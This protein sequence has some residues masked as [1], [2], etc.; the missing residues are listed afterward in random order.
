[1][2]AWFARVISRKNV[3]T[4]CLY[5]LGGLLYGV[6]LSDPRYALGAWLAVVSLAA[7]IQ[8]SRSPYAVLV[9]VLLAHLLTR[10]IAFPWVLEM[11]RVIFPFS[12]ASSPQYM[13]RVEL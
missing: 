8:R 2:K 5:I 3:L 7:G 4:F 9:G 6:S 11:N 10:M 1:M 12:Q 13:P